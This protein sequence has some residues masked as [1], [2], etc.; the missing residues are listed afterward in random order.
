MDGDEPG[1]HPDIDANIADNDNIGGDDYEFDNIDSS[2]NGSNGNNSDSGGDGGSRKYNGQGYEFDVGSSGGG[3]DFGVFN[4]CEGDDQPHA[5]MHIPPTDDEARDAP[6]IQ[7]FSI[8]Q[9]L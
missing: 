2:D 6:P 7:I 9:G 3:D 8:A 1:G 4:F 5:T